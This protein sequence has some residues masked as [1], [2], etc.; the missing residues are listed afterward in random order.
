[1]SST[2]TEA[3]DIETASGLLPWHAGQWQALMQRRQTDTLPHAVLLTGIQ[4]LGKNRFADAL[5]QALLCGHPQTDG[6]ACQSCRSC[7]LYQAAT[8]PDYLCVQP[9]EDR[10]VII[11]NQIR[12]MNEFIS[13]K[14]QYGGYQIVIISPADKMNSNAANSL[15]KTLEEP[16]AQTLL[17]LITHEASALPATVRSRC[18]QIKFAPPAEQLAANWLRTHIKDDQDPIHLL[19]LAGSAPLTALS[20]AASDACTRRALMLDDLESLLNQQADPVS[21]AATWLKGNVA[22]TLT[23]MLSCIIDMV[24]L[25]SDARPPHLANPDL[26]QRLSLLAGQ[27]SSAMLYA[28]LDCVT[29]A[30]KLLNSQVNTQLLLED[31]LLSWSNTSRVREKNL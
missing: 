28:H 27:F 22:E 14:S 21:L 29:E 20:M 12:K 8:H 5:T 30:I 26:Q 19:A 2:T 16:P 23:W 9:T 10:K 6:Q 11:V 31:M 25:R 7:L 13:L 17:M 18:L 1:M 15:L 24:R 4:G 3:A